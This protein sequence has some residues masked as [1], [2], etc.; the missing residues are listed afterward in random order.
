[1]TPIQTGILGGIA[2]VFFL[3]SSMPVAFAMAL[4]GIVGFAMLTTST[5]A[6]SMASAEL[7]ETF[8]SYSLTVI[9]L[10]VFMGQVA[11]HAGISKSLFNAAYKWLGAL[12]GGLAMATVGACTAF[13]AI[14]GSGPATA[15]TMASVAI[16]EMR[17]Y[18]YSMELASG[19]V[20]AGGSLGMLIPPSVVFIVYAILTESSIGKL[21]IA[22]VLPGLMIAALFCLTIYIN[23]RRRPE[24]GPVGPRASLGEKIRSLAGVAE[25]LILF[26]VVMGGM[27]LGFFTPTEAA[28]VGAAGSLIIAL[29]KRKLS[30]KILIRSLLETARTSSMVMMIVAGAVIFGRFLAITRIPYELANWLS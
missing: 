22:G 7:Y 21:F 20:A 24:M 4:V 10:F 18:N 17:R 26:I 30:I 19:A 9:P 23:C 14:C 11:F 1:M 25:T 12:P 15:A 8:S 5:A 13:G 29:V 2:L 6:M 28:A 27:F 16:P 3:I